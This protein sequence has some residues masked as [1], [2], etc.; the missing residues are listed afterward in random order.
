M[1]RS[2]LRI[3]FTSL[4]LA[5]IGV[6][7]PTF[8]AGVHEDP[9][10]GFKVKVPDKWTMVPVDI[11]EKWIVGKYLCNRDYAAKTAY[12]MIKPEMRIFHFTPEK[13]KVTEKV[14]TRGDTT[15]TSRV[16][17]FR[18]YLEWYKEFMKGGRGFHVESEKED[19]MGDVLVTKLEIL[20][21]QGADGALRYL[22]WVFKRPDGSTVAID[23]NQLDDYYKNV[24]GDFEK[25]LRSFRFFE[26]T[27][28]A[29]GEGDELENPIWTRDRS[30]WRELPKSERWKIRQTMDTKRRA[31]VLSHIPEG[32]TTQESRSKRFTAL[33]H[34]DKK[35]TSYILDTADATW[36]WLDKKFAD[37]SDE[38][39]M[40]GTIRIC[41]SV[42][43]AAS[44]GAKS[45]DWNSYS[46]DDREIVTWKDRDSG[47]SGGGWNRLLMTSLLTS[48]L[49]DKDY[50]A[51]VYAPVWLIVGSSFYLSTADLDGRR[52]NFKSDNI[53][54]VYVREAER[55]GSL[56]TFNELI[57]T[58]SDDWPKERQ[59]V[60][61]YLFQL[62]AM[63]R[64]LESREASRFKFLDKF[65]PRYVA[66]VVK[67][68]EQ[69]EKAHP[70]RT[71]A[72]TEAEEEARAKDRS[73]ENREREKFVIDT[74]NKEVANFSQK[75][76]QQLEAA[77]KAWQTK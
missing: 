25:C 59:A 10:I 5:G 12:V 70:G 26:P 21:D 16:A 28:A 46:A 58:A 63:V 51:I 53:E 43:E 15:Y 9:T 27:A 3:S 39:V 38:Y 31:K 49:R 18:N 60:I 45:N 30:K 72:K 7:Q 75:E 13:A 73:K 64:F 55:E 50:Y 69:W 6:A 22:C 8:Q 24:A 67:A 4:V 68:G 41:E 61:R 34:A 48:Y 47:T 40:V 35:Y 56:R 77:W 42:D 2:T 62:S 19:K 74:V 36:E 54:K 14:E 37:L 52:L 57:T 71:Q 65:I 17:T 1:A 66:A 29:G 23:F 32:W 44:Y 33:T 20:T 76:W 11:D